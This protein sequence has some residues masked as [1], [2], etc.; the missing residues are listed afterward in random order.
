MKAQSELNWVFILVAG[1]I[2]IVFFTGFAFKYK[3]LQEEKLSIELLT[4]LDNSLT[5]LQS[6]PYNTITE[7]NLLK[8]IEIKCNEIK[9]DNEEFKTKKLIFS[10]N[11][12]KNKML[13]YYKPFK[14][15]FKIA[16]FYFIIDGTKN[17]IYPKDQGSRIY[18]ENLKENL[19]EKFK[20][21]FNIVNAKGK[22]IQINQDSFTIN[23]K[24]Y[25]LHEDLVY[26]SILSNDFE[27]LYEKIKEKTNKAV[28]V[29]QN[30]AN[31]LNQGNCNYGSFTP[32][33]NKL[34]TLNF[35]AISSIESL[36]QNLVG[37]NC[38]ALY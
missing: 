29:Y 19:P 17:N 8:D 1:A 32:Y 34:K 13:I 20:E 23:N 21:N 31:M 14:V 25:P 33:L 9:I 6:S 5:S 16:D 24:Q 10:Q 7:I 30:K 36:N 4:K 11:K 12:L 18:L 35:N 26:A 38:P 3:S 2:I 15:P 27:C 28:I 37:R 22:E